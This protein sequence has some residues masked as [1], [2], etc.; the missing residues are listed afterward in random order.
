MRDIQDKEIKNFPQARKARVRRMV[1]N[2][3]TS[4]EKVSL[5]GIRRRLIE[6]NEKWNT[7]D[8]RNRTNSL[9]DLL[10]NSWPEEFKVPK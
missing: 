2:A 8:I 6:K 3:N 1:D 7:K 10:E 5:Q 4:P 9:I